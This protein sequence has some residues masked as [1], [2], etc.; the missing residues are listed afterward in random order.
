VCKLAEESHLEILAVNTIRPS[1]ED[2]FIKITG[3][4][5]TVMAMEKGAK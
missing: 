5:P 4:S 1:L 2:A 3:L